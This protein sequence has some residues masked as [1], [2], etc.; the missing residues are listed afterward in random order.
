ME[1][2][3]TI[4]VGVTSIGTFSSCR[5]RWLFERKWRSRKVSGP[6]YL[7]SLVH[8]FL[9]GFYSFIKETGSGDINAAI[10]RGSESFTKTLYTLSDDASELAK[11]NSDEYVVDLEVLAQ[12]I[13][14]NYANHHPIFFSDIMGIEGELWHYDKNTD[15]LLRGRYDMIVRLPNGKLALVDHKV[16]SRKSDAI[17]TALTFDNQ[18]NMYAFMAAQHLDEPIS[19]IIHNVLYARVPEKPAVLKNGSL[20]RS[21]STL[22]KTTYALYMNA[23]M[24]N[25]LDAAE[26]EYELEFLDEREL[27]TASPYFERVEIQV[28]E[29]IVENLVA[30]LAPRFADMREVAQHPEKAYRTN[31]VFNCRFCPFL[32]VCYAD[33]IGIDISSMLSTHY[34][35]VDTD[36]V[37]IPLETEP[38]D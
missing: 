31:S 2:T 30:E 7:G 32:D 5:K 1:V 19:T 6:M 29:S 23:I 12:Q 10:L 11:L 25:K 4:K 15:V 38:E 36:S 13:C 14:L 28:Y 24:E 9:E 22:E 8:G 34:K 17:H 33:L 16:R 37:S 20:S 35:A 18:V 3:D 21:K 27:T 26:Y